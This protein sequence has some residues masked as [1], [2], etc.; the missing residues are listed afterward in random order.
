MWREV[1]DELWL[2]R[3]T[4]SPDATRPNGSHDGCGMETPDAVSGVQGKGV[5]KP[6]SWKTSAGRGVGRQREALTSARPDVRRIPC[7][8]IR[9]LR[10]RPPHGSR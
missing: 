4:S 8:Y 7:F 5:R 3:D 9:C 10:I 1:V 6:R 2:D